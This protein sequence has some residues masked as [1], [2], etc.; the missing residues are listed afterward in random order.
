[1]SETQ[2]TPLLIVLIT[3]GCCTLWG[4]SVGAAFWDLR[5]I[6]VHGTDRAAWLALVVLVP[7]VGMLGYLT[8]RMLG[9]TLSPDSRLP[10]PGGRRRKRVTAIRRP[11]HFA[12]RQTTIPAEEL[13]RE[14][15]PESQIIRENHAHPH[16]LILLVETGPHAGQTFSIEELPVTLGRGALADVCFDQDQGISRLHAE[17][18]LKAGV[19][20]L[21]DLDSRHGTHVNEFSISD[22]EIM[23]GD[24]IR[25]G[26]TDM[27]LEQ[28]EAVDNV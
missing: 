16:N 21:R 15:R 23:P 9:S 20:R 12:P 2:F 26:M 8:W 28:V 4:I 13:L 6:G 19:L 17:I 24:R 14:T 3:T 27:I 10:E 5:R 22:K 25:L 11:D 18:Y 7:G 1:M